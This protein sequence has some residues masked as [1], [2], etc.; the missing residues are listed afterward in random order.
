M[1]S[2]T[3]RHTL[4]PVA[5]PCVTMNLD[6]NTLD[7]IPISMSNSGESKKVAIVYCLEYS[8]ELYRKIKGNHA[9]DMSL[10]EGNQCF[11]WPS[12]PSKIMFSV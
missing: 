10:P 12:P 3:H 1:V 2:H 4:Y 11:L 7:L 6:L 9:V 8:K 5:L